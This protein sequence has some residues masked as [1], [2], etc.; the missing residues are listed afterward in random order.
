MGRKTWPIGEA[1]L[2]CAQPV[3]NEN[4]SSFACRKLDFT[5]MSTHN[6]THASR[7][8]TNIDR[9]AFSPV[10][11]LSAHFIMNAMNINMQ[12]SDCEQASFERSFASASLCVCAA[13][14]S[15]R[16]MKTRVFFFLANFVAAA[17]LVCCA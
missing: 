9:V 8:S 11:L 3:A 1:S 6:H 7:Q 4:S 12:A 14:P 5:R 15:A 10:H 17:L 16:L 2:F 13:S